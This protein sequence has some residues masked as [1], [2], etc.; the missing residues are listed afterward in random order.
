MTPTSSQLPLTRRSQLGPPIMV[1]AHVH[2]HECFHLGQFLD[3]AARNFTSAIHDHA[4][5][6]E[7]A[8]ALLLTEVEGACVFD[9]LRAASGVLMSQL[10]DWQAYSTPDPRALLF[11]S[12]STLPL[13]LIAGRQIRVRGRLEV[14]ALGCLDTFPDGM[15]IEEALRRTRDSSSLPVLPWGFGKW[16]LSRGRQIRE[17]IVHEDPDALCLGDVGG[18]WRGLS[19]PSLLAEGRSRGFAVLPGS[20]PLPFPGHVGRA[21]SSGLVLP[22]ALQLDHAAED[23]LQSLPQDE[24]G[25]VTY[26]ELER[27]GPFVLHQIRM[28]LRKI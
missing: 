2:I 11:E 1:D 18:R 27:L 9:S 20:D 16:T 12:P 3:A 13:L 25:A 17:L 22:L 6:Q 26:M 7:A 19:E 10:G 21:G 5:R 14:L 24:T 8:G 28:Q 15:A 4:N 23:L